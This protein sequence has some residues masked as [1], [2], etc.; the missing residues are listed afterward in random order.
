MTIINEF[1]NEHRWIGALLKHKKRYKALSWKIPAL[2]NEIQRLRKEGKWEEIKTKK[3]R[4]KQLK[5]AHNDMKAKRYA[6]GA[7][8]IGYL[9][10]KGKKE[11]EY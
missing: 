4:L 6:V 5:K 10:H 11:R 9:G 1:L 8:G 3:R 7:V 2:K